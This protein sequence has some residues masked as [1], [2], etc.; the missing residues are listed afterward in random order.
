LDHEFDPEK[1]WVVEAGDLRLPQ[2]GYK[3]VP[4]IKS[5]LIY[6]A[7]PSD[8][9]YHHHS[10]LT[11]HNG[12]FYAAFSEGSS[13]EDGPGQRVRITTSR[14]GKI[15]NESTLALDALD[16]Y[17]LDW[18]EVGRM[19][20]PISWVIVDDRVWVICDVTDVI[21]FS[22]KAGSS[23]IVSKVRKSGLQRVL[24][25]VGLFASEV[26]PDGTIGEQFWIME[27]PPES[28]EDSPYGIFSTIY[29][30]KYDMFRNIFLKEVKMF[31]TGVGPVE[32]LKNTRIANDGHRLAEHTIYRRPDG[33]WIQLARDLN[34]SHFLYYSESIDGL[35]FSVPVRTNI[36]DSP[37]K[38][39]AGSLPDGR[40]YIIGNFVHNPEKDSTKKHYK[41]YPL[42]LA[43]SQDGKIF[44]R[45]Y[46]IRSEPTV[47]RFEVGGS[48]DGY[49]YPDAVVVADTLWIIYSVN[50]Q[51]ICASKLNWREL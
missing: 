8:G 51:D 3:L 18:K 7:K 17:S 33:Q 28:I 15:W 35:T 39:V 49:Q 25:F 50:K 22:N 11:Y 40:S 20:T 27:D 24:V 19:S 4:G 37:S 26:L 44:D 47:P 29:D 42:V 31:K 41:R 32:R 16:D 1:M 14:N 9:A 13:G 12:I 34:Y 2:A 23:K 30:T 46:A 48:S 43:L 38:T 10:S 45:A 6:L 21:G 36:P 5:H